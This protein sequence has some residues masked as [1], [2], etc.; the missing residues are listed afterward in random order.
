[1]LA[2]DRATGCNAELQNPV[3]QR[4]RR[5]LLSWNSLVVQH[6]RVEVAVARMKHISNEKAGFFAKPVDFVQELR[7]GGSRDHAVL[8]DVVG[9][10]APHSRK[11]GLASLPE[12]GAL[13][14]GLR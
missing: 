13:R 11:C 10:D 3:R 6:E 1:M 8:N 9:R 4:F 12:Q 2:G 14:I 5:L 7:Q